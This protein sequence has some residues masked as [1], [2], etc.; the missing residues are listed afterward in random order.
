MKIAHR[1]NYSARR[2][3]AYP[4]IGDQLD[5]IR[6]LAE[7]LQTVVPLSSEVE[8]WLAE[9]QRVKQRFPKP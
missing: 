1:S 8:Q 7:T 9:L 2:A 3:E 5:A 4:P 6:Q